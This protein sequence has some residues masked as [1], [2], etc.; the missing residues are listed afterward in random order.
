MKRRCLHYSYPLANLLGLPRER[1]GVG[2]RVV[3]DGGEEL[4]LV[5]AVEGRL[6]DEHLVELWGN[7]NNFKHI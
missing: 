2:D 5:L 3:G 7:S 6:P 1:L 4:L